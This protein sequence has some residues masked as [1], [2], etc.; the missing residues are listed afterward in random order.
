MHSSNNRSLT[1]HLTVV[2]LVAWPLNES[3]AGVGLVQ[4]DTSRRLLLFYATVATKSRNLCK[5]VPFLVTISS[6]FNCYLYPFNNCFFSI[7]FVLLLVKLSI[8]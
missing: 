4:I 2:C 1:D 7:R 8:K 3:V 5:F 6:Y